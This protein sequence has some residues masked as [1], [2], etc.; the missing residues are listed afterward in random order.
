MTKICLCWDVLS[1]QG[2]GIE[3]E[4]WDVRFIQQLKEF[5]NQMSVK[6]SGAAMK[7]EKVPREP[8][9]GQSFWQPLSIPP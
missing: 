3:E 2:I 4:K 6:N 1:L 5:G 8:S 7:W 9:Y